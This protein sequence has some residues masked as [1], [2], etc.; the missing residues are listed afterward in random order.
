M[1]ASKAQQAKTAERRTRAI[2]LKVAGVPYDTIAQQ[3]GYASR[4]AACTDIDRAL[5]QRRRD[6][7]VRSGSAVAL[8]IE[9]LETMERTAWAVLRRT[10]VVVSHGRVIL[11]A[12]QQ[13][14]T[15]DA[16]TLNAIDRL[17]K[18]QERRAKLL[19]LDAP[20]RVEVLTDD[21]IDAEIRRLADELGAG[22]PGE[23]AAP[24]GA[25]GREAAP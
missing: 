22:A 8:E 23:A 3:L 13:P 19:G 21:A 7:D 1:P 20:T 2:A 25:E 15:D 24:A 14:M 10:H 16:P 6:L 11:D 4:G 9:R 12:N 18:I 5:K 17:L